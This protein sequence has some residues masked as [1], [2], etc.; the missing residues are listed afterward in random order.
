MLFLILKSRTSLESRKER[1][2]L[3]EHFT[4]KYIDSYIS[5]TEVHLETFIKRLDEVVE[6]NGGYYSKINR[7]VSCYVYDTVGGIWFLY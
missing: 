2:V 5:K 1:K 6:R 7:L 4:L 3:K